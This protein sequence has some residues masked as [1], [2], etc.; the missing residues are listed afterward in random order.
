MRRRVISEKNK[1]EIYWVDTEKAIKLHLKNLDSQKS[2]LLKELHGVESEL[3]NDVLDNRIRQANQEVQ[4]LQKE[5]N[6]K[7]ESILART[8]SESL[9]NKSSKMSH[10]KC[11]PYPKK[12]MNK[13][14][15]HASIN[16]M[17]GEWKSRKQQCVEFVDQLAD[18]MDKKPTQVINMLDIETDE[19]AGEKLP[20]KRDI[21]PQPM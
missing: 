19:K 1:K 10:P 4:E 8:K 17:R 3:S 14:Q 5:V 7:R 16:H 20:P 9:P 6:D 18:A 2:D 21:N 13:R 12:K 11:K 15:L